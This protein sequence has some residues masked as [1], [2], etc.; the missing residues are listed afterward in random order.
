MASTYGPPAAGPSRG[1]L[2]SN[3]HTSSVPMGRSGRP[4]SSERCSRDAASRQTKRLFPSATEATGQPTPI[5]STACSAIRA[6]ETT[7]VLGRNGETGP[8]FLS[9]SPNA[10]APACPSTVRTP[11]PH[12]R[13]PSS[14][15]HR[16][17]CQDV[18]TA[19][20]HEGQGGSGLTPSPQADKMR[21]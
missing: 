11:H 14:L 2:T 8:T 20:P 13:K 4:Q 3:G 6:H 9:R 7:S 12:R 5:L 16:T 19:A 21:R 10:E 15:G 18:T 17:E 1:L